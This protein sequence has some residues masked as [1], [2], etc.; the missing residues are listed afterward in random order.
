MTY[1]LKGIPASAGIT[2]GPIYMYTVDSTQYTAITEH[3][4][5]NP[6]SEWQCFN[7]ALEHS[8]DQVIA[9]R[10]RTLAE[11][12]PEKAEIFA[13]HVSILKDPEFLSEIRKK[14]FNE[15]KS[16]VTAVR[17]TGEIFIELLKQLQDDLFSGRIHD[18]QDIVNRL[19]Q[20]I[21]G[22][23]EETLHLKTASVVAAADLTPS[24]TARLDRSLV[25][26][27]ITEGGSAISHSSILARSLGI[28]AVVG[29][30]PLPDISDG[31]I[32]V[33]DGTSGTVIINPN[34]EVLFDYEKKRIA[35]EAEQNLVREYAGKP[36]KT[37]DGI[38]IEISANIGSLKDLEAV[39]QH[40][41]DG[42][43]LFRTEFM[44]M[45]RQT[46]PT[47]DEQF[48]VYKHVLHRMNGKP[49]VIRTLD[50][51]GDKQIPYIHLETEANPFLGVRAIRLCLQKEELFRTQI[52][53]LLRASSF[54]RL[55]I[56]LPMVATLEEL[57]T[58]KKIIAEETTNLKNSGITVSDSW[59]LGIMIEIPSA[60]LLADYFAAEVD[61]FSVGTND[62]TQYTMAADRMNRSLAYLNQGLA[63]AVLK[64]IELTA[65]AA[66][67]HG[68][69][70]GVCGELAGD[71]EVFP[72][73]IGLGITELSMGSASV[74]KIRSRLAK[75]TLQEATQ[76]ASKALCLESSKLIYT[77]MSGVIS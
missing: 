26:G 25:L 69:W 4:A 45:G 22:N 35:Y 48:E 21:Q 11:L 33:V 15:H 71:S 14:I 24:Q 29:L 19:V 64:L 60:A 61:F 20:N 46:M 10:D 50:V 54:G 37:K 76:W 59:E 1:T 52:R 75:F 18:I 5:E 62:L 9:L 58:A 3:G 38:E 16:A 63:P 32:V 17:E 49:V 31:A 34:P 36:S 39:F 13:S 44:F 28:P 40:G 77:F 53:A 7:Q 43:G 12:G 68:I 73:F 2:I 41:A 30:G 65:R 27:F 72:L 57:R 51:G 67:A 56:L 66:L 23:E 47:E 42:I 74:P 8:K 6:D 70:I 55:R